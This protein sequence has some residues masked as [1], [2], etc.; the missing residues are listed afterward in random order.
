MQPISIA[1]IAAD[2]R[3]RRW[4]FQ[5]MR[6]IEK[7][8]NSK[9]H[10]FQS[11]SPS[12][13]ADFLLLKRQMIWFFGGARIQSL[14]YQRDSIQQTR[15]SL[16]CL[17]VSAWTRAATN[18]RRL[19]ASHCEHYRIDTKS[20]E[21]LVDDLC[22]SLGVAHYPLGNIPKMPY[23]QTQNFQIEAWQPFVLGHCKSKIP[24]SHSMRPSAN[25]KPI[26]EAIEPIESGRVWT[27]KKKNSF[28]MNPLINCNRPGG[29]RS[30]CD[31]IVVDNL[32]DAY[33]RMPDS[34]LPV[35]A[36]KLIIFPSSLTDLKCERF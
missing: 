6:V 15:F 5:M 7:L 10:L 21:L 12:V 20:N 25:E 2:T 17:S 29:S 9:T 31:Y 28:K 26:E 32:I 33:I 14:L 4:W 19:W 27:K 35:R 11:G 13:L 24:S 16:R 18:N 1:F 22:A 30:C 36:T 8:K 3:V 23:L 34:L